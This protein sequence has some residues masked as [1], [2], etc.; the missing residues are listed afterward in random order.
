MENS[1]SFDVKPSPTDH[2]D[3]ALRLHLDNHED[4]H[5]KNIDKMTLELLVNK[6]Q[7]RKY[8][9][10]CD[11]LSY[12]N[13]REEYELVNKYKYDIG[14]LFRELLNDYSISGNS[15]HLGN[16]EIHHIFEA[17]V[18][19]SA[20]YFEETRNSGPFIDEYVEENTM[21]AHIDEP[22]S[23]GENGLC[24]ELFDDPALSSDKYTAPFVNQFRDGNSFWGK[25]ITKQR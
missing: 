20:Y 10:K 8:L 2:L 19:K 5:Q 4:T 14:L 13:K 7:Y 16:S 22:L 24:N 17:F 9:E 12:D 1:L 23:R 25:N 6:R 18:K 21:F 15:V 11:P 3:G